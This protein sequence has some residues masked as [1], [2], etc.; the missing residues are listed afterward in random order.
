MGATIFYSSHK[1]LL[2]ITVIKTQLINVH[3]FTLKI[4]DFW[5]IQKNLQMSIVTHNF[6]NITFHSD[7]GFSLRLNYKF[8]HASKNY[9]R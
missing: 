7:F 5:M 1:S 8:K 4:D 6:A 9:R 3:R 2:S